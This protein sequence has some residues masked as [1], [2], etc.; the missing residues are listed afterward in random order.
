MGL[1]IIGTYGR[2]AG[3][4]FTINYTF[5]LN[6]KDPILVHVFSVFPLGSWQYFRRV[7]P[8]G[9]IQRAKARHLE[10]AF[11]GCSLVARSGCALCF[12]PCYPAILKEPLPG[13]LCLSSLLLFL[14][15]IVVTVIQR[16]SVLETYKRR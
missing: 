14:S 10:Q 15:I 11:N 2:Y 5:Y 8:P 13:P 1:V 3:V 12:L 6:L 16:W 9:V 4:H 7:G